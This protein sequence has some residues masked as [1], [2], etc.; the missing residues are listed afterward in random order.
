[1]QMISFHNSLGQIVTYPIVAE[2]TDADGFVYYVYGPVPRG[3]Y[4][5]RPT[6]DIRQKD[7]S[8]WRHEA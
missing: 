6:Y 2:F 5:T 7:G 4:D 3:I 8:E 1:M